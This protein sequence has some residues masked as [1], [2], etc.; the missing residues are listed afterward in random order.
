MRYFAFISVIVFFC[1]I[2][3]FGLFIRTHAHIKPNISCNMHY[4][5]DRNQIILA[6]DKT[7]YK[8]YASKDIINS[9][10]LVAKDVSLTNKEIKEL[11]RS[12]T[13]IKYFV[14]EYLL[15]K[16][17]TTIGFFTNN[18]ICKGVEIN[19]IKGPVYTTIDMK[20]QN[21]V[22][23]QCEKGKLDFN[24]DECFAVIVNMQGEI[25]SM[26]TTNCPDPNK[27]KDFFNSINQGLFEFGSTCKPFTAFAGL[28]LNK[29]NEQTIFDTSLGSYID[30]RKMND[31]EII[32]QYS[33]LYTIMKHSSN[34]GLVTMAKIIGMELLDV[35]KMLKLNE[36]IK[37]DFGSTPTPRWYKKPTLGDVQTMS[38][39]YYPTNCMNMIRAYLAIFNY[40]T[41]INPSVIKGKTSVAGKI[42]ANPEVFRI[43]IEAMKHAASKEPTLNQY[44]CASK[45]GTAF[46][47]ANGTY[48]RSAVNTFIVCGVP[49]INHKIKALI[50]VG[51]LNPRSVLL[52]G[53][54]VRKICVQIVKDIAPM[55][56]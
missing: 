20:I 48:D 52:A 38:F 51:L 2:S 46:R 7:K 28:Y 27:P 26:H 40:G 21:V 44:H 50:F 3:L 13:I 23:M 34:L 32:P 41:L 36:S 47:I 15:G 25:L 4:I 35:L 30:N 16:Y 55:I 12:S 10:T 9:S 24:A 53:L 49:D 31:V 22:A 42:K 17:F 39:G 54:S 43:T 8:I 45:T 29:F 33:N 14:R 11:S 19:A 1:I 56:Q 37:L 5:Y 6:Y 18:G